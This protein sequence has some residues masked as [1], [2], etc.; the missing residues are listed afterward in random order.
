MEN[1]DPLVITAIMFSSMLVLMAL[2]APLAWALTICGIASAYSI[3]GDGG[4][5]LLISI[6]ARVERMP[7]PVFVAE[8]L[9][10]VASMATNLD[11]LKTLIPPPLVAVFDD[12]SATPASNVLLFM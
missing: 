3:Y 1:L 7:P 4:L 5:D 2:G 6:L 9:L 11:S 12:T 8:L 10:I